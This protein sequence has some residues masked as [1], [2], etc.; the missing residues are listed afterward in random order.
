MTSTT[1]NDKR[2]DD[3]LARQRPDPAQLVLLYGRRRVGKTALLLRWVAQNDIPYTYW[4]MERG[5]GRPKAFDAIIFSR[6][7]SLGRGSVL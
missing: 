5:Y 7:I 4:A 2:D 6:V 1:R 3:I